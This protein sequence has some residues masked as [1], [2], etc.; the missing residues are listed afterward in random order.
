MSEPI[1][2]EQ[3]IKLYK[4]TDRRN[5]TKNRTVWG[6]NVT[7]TTTGIPAELCSTGWL[8]AYEHF[9]L[10][11]M[12]NPIHANFADPR[13]WEA[14][15]SGQILRD[16]QLKCG[17][18]ELTTVREIPLPVVTIEQRVRFAILCGKAV[19]P[20]KSWNGWADKW[21]SGEDR[22]V[23]KAAEAWAAWT[24]A[25]AAEAS[26][27]SWAAR[28]ATEEAR[29]EARAAEWSSA[30]AARAAASAA[31]W[32]ARVARAADEPTLDLIKLAEAVNG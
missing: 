13:L 21:L 31:E 16:G 29:E 22:S 24:T 10:A 15:G 11:V 20:D 8:H 5:R 23:A 18:T 3:P 4:L 19:C 12:I 14:Y 17:V 27:A 32:S 30:Q 1:E 9:L 2:L 25:W 6:E 26:A 28:A 7:H